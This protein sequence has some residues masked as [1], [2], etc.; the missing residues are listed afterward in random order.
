MYS[1]KTGTGFERVSKTGDSLILNNGEVF[2]V[3]GISS[4]NYGVKPTSG[5][6]NN[7]VDIDGNS[8]KTVYI[9]SQLWMAENLKT[10]K[11]RD[12]STITNLTD[13]RMWGDDLKGAWCYYNNDVTN[14]YKYGKLYNWYA[15]SSHLNGNK[16]VCPIGWHIPVESEWIK[17]I[18][19][20]GGTPVTGGKL[21]EVG[22]NLWKTPNASATNSVLFSA[23]PGGNRYDDGSF[24]GVTIYGDWW[25]LSCIQNGSAVGV[26]VSYNTAALTKS[27]FYSW[28]NGFSVRCVKD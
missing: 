13:N 1:G 27:P 24:S 26:S 20:L 28:G 11:Y 12:G 19:F 25:A 6:G 10:T 17:L 3:P 9:G 18:D 21:K 15:I 5:S 16:E 14:N 22:T 23:L 7:L 8:Y 2:I 4:E